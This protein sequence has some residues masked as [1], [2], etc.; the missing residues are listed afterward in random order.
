MS[1]ADQNEP[2]R[3]SSTL[4]TAL[5]ALD[6]AAE[7]PPGDGVALGNWRWR[8]RQQIGPVRDALL[9]SSPTSGD[10][11][12]AARGGVA[13]RERN[14]LLDRLTALN[15]EVLAEPDPHQVRQSV[16]R[17]VGDVTHHLQ[18]VNDL[19]YD[20]VEMEIGGSD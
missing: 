16:R 3:R 6:R 9:G 5:R 13:F 2:A 4:S 11:W 18:R 17:L 14:A 8:V 20:E 1:G 7:S 12:L 19:A 15:H 10:G